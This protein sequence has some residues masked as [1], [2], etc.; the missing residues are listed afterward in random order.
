MEFSEVLNYILYIVLTV[1]LPIVATYVVNLI[2]AKIAESNI[3]AETT[4]N[5]DISRLV[6]DTLC[7]IMD[8]VLYVNQTFTDALKQKGEFNE[9]AQ[10][11]AF[12]KAYEKAIELISQEAKDVIDKVYGSFDE[13][14]K[15]K[16]ESSVN[17]AKK[18]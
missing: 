11:E 6:K 5:E 13:W 3:I 1:I 4:R 16:I 10:K 8:A 15:L 2:K 17:M 12:D 18:Q 9:E 7:D 14:L